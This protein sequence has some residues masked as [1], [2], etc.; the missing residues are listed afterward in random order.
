MIVQETS[1]WSQLASYFQHL[2]HNI[3]NSDQ[4]LLFQVFP[5]LGIVIL[6]L[7]LVET[8]YDCTQKHLFTSHRPIQKSKVKSK[9]NPT[10][11]YP[12]RH[13]WWCKFIQNI[14]L[15]GYRNLLI[16]I[17]RPKY[18]SIGGLSSPISWS[19]ILRFPI[20]LS[21]KEEVLNWN[22]MLTLFI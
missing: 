14:I 5:L 19:V 10:Q 12:M 8:P 20:G 6:V 18:L 21:I 17:S 13:L 9:F 22:S 3:S 11:I 2:N 16:L 1:H 4:W 15:K 7:K